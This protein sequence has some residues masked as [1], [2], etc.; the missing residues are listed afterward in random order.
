[1]KKKI[2][3]SPQKNPKTDEEMDQIVQDDIKTF[4]NNHSSNPLY[5]FTFVLDLYTKIT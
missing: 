5:Y 3:D 2:K 4:I 1:M